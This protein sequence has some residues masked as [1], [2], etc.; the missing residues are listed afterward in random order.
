MKDP[1]LSGVHFLNHEFDFEFMVKNRSEVIELAD[2]R[3]AHNCF[4]ETILLNISISRNS[5][6]VILKLIL[7]LYYIFFQIHLL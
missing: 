4:M 1:A 7:I 2:I 3:V 5:I 6:Y